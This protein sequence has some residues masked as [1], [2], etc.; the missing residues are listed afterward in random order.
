MAH[1]DFGILN[2]GL[3]HEENEFVA[4]QRR[5]LFFAQSSFRLIQNLAALV[6]LISL[7]VSGSWHLPSV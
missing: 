4:D 6:A 3:L 1:E 2:S 5:K 7:T